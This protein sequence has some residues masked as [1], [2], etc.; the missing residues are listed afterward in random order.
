MNDVEMTTKS[1]DEMTH[2][3]FAAELDKDAVELQPIRKTLKEQRQAEAKAV[4][5]PATESD[6]MSEA[7]EDAS[8]DVDNDP[9]DY[10][11]IAR[12]ANARPKS[13][14]TLRREA[15][16]EYMTAEERERQMRA[17][18]GEIGRGLLPH[19]EVCNGR[20]AVRGKS[21]LTGK[22]LNGVY[23]EDHIYELIAALTTLSVDN[24]FI[25]WATLNPF[26]DSIKTTNMLAPGY[27]IGGDKITRVSWLVIDFDPDRPSKKNNEATAEERDRARGVMEMVREFLTTQWGFPEPWVV[28][29]GNGYQMKYRVDLLPTTI[30][31]TLLKYVLLILDKLYPLAQTGVEIDTCMWDLPRICKIAGTYSRKGMPTDERPQMLAQTVSFPEEFIVIEAEVLQQFVSAHPDLVE[32]EVAVEKERQE[33]EYNAE[34][35]RARTGGGYLSVEEAHARVQDFC[36]R[37]SILYTT[38]TSDGVTYYRLDRC[39]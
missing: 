28:M 23:D 8:G 1:L 32:E 39:F 37:H 17:M 26:A 6:T 31:T 9:W 11:E 12:Q 7:V 4:N 33:R 18:A 24:A 36:R 22:L 5:T 38:D 27:G 19:F 30:S 34:K 21:L 35:M 25:W 2:E 14:E 13:E 15:W 3:E 20:L 29:S 16:A 10:E